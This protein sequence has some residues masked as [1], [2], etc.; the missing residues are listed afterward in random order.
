MKNISKSWQ[1]GFDSAKVASLHSNAPRIS[2][3]MGA[4]LYSGNKLLSVGY[5]LFYKTHP[6]YT[7]YENGEK[8]H[9]NVHAE[10]MALLKRQHYSNTNLIMYVYR[11]LDNGDLGC[12]EPCNMCY[13]MMEVAGVSKVRFINKGGHYEEV[14]L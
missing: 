12:S 10:W 13:N 3:R 11:E 9:K 14:K 2:K 6:K 8:F 4:A 1:K 5:N 7:F